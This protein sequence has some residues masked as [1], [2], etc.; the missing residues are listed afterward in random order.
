MLQK[1]V[2]VGG[3]PFGKVPFTED[4]TTTKKKEAFSLTLKQPIASFPRRKMKILSGWHSLK[5]CVFTESDFAKSNCK[6][7]RSPTWWLVLRVSLI[8]ESQADHA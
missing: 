1:Y 4:E 8:S 3:V 7:E 5:L 2:A 6:S